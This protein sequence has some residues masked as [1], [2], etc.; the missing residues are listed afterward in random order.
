MTENSALSRVLT[1]QHHVRTL[2]GVT[3]IDAAVT[4]FR[5]STAVEDPAAAALLREVG[6]EAMPK[7]SPTTR[8]R[9]RG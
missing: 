6:H 3:R 8:S 9:R 2:L 1:R 5:A 4:F 7:Q